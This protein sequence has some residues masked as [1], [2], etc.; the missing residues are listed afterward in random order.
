MS[1]PST[2]VV[3]YNLEDEGAAIDAASV[4][5]AATAIAGALTERGYRATTATIR[6][7]DVFEVLAQLRADR[8]DL[9]FNLCEAMAGDSRNEP[10]FVGL[11]DLF[12]IPY[13]GADLLGLASC[14]YKQRAKDILLGRGVSTPPYRLIDAATLDDPDHAGLDYPWFVKLVHEDASVGITE[15]NVVH[16]AAELRARSRELIE[17]YA[18]PVLAER[19]VEGREINVTLI[20]NGASPRVLPLHEI[21]FAAMPADRPRI[22]S[23]AAKWDDQH[24]DYEGTKPVPIRDASPALVEAIERT[25]RAAWHALGLRDYGRVDLRVDAAGVPWVIDVNPNCDISPDAGVAR[26]ARVA[27][28]TYPELIELIALTAWRRLAALRS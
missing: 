17:R 15:A 5:D 21:D 11:L 28:M 25:A 26:S 14:L 16:S 6:G 20:G 8:P 12:G 22:V 19:Y 2:I 27:G 13:T 4:A 18:Q 7:A 3:L 23:Y 9:V 1:R 10:T 24:V